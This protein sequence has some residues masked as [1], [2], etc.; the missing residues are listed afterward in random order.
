M[1]PNPGILQLIE[2]YYVLYHGLN[3]PCCLHEKV[4]LYSLTYSVKN[5]ACR[6]HRVLFR[7]LLGEQTLK[8][9]MTVEDDEK[10]VLFI[11]PSRS[12]LTRDVLCGLRDLLLAHLTPLRYL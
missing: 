8:V 11:F 2:E 5:E 12:T 10:S 3:Q 9:S 6:M 1:F 4:F 7:K